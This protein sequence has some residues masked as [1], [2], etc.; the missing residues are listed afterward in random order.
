MRIAFIV[1]FSVNLLFTV[2]AL[3]LCPGEVAI[4]F[5]SG[6]NPNDWAPAH[7]N[8]LIM[9]GVNVVVFVSFFFT[10]FLL[11]VTPRRWVNLPN[12]DYWFKDENK[13]KMES[14]LSFH[15]Y[16]FGIL[17]FVF[18]FFVSALVL[19]AN[20]STPVRLREELLW[21]PLGLYMAYTLYWSIKI[22][23]LFRIPKEGFTHKNI[24]KA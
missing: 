14:I 2:V 21:W 9:T 19:Q 6:G 11:R 23:L 10:P 24:D 22:L 12:K 8:A 15:M 20:M 4:H 16:Q 3:F 17:T 13:G 7:V 1:A 5:G 18:V